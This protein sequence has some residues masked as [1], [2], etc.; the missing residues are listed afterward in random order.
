M[1]NRLWLL[2]LLAACVSD[3]DGDDALPKRGE[4]ATDPTILAASASCVSGSHPTLDV[5]VRIEA[6]DPKGLGNLGTCT[7][8]IAGESAE[9]ALDDGECLAY[10]PGPCTPGESFLVD[11]LVTNTTGGF[12]QASLKMTA[13]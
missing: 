6:S 9:D 1:A 13:R 10:V 7:A 4:R 8:T 2:V 11:L 3:R 5:G 12:T